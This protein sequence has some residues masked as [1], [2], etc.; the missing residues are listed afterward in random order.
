M[1]PSEIREHILEERRRTFE[2]LDEVRQIAQTVFERSE[3]E[4]SALHR[5][6]ARLEAQLA[7]LYEEEEEIL[8]PALR[9]TDAFGAER[10]RRLEQYHLQQREVVTACCG[11]VLA[12]NL[13]AWT[14][15][16]ELLELIAQVEQGL[17][18]SERRFLSPNLLKDDLVSIGQSGG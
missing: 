17:R 10:A 13:P 1:H 6:A 8:D 11:E 5:A 18:R 3:E 9:D 7:R 16:R 12:G 4:S 14:A 2:I 15:A